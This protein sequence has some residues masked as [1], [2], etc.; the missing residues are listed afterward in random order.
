MIKRLL[1]KVFAGVAYGD[2]LYNAAEE[3]ELKDVVGTPA[4][5]IFVEESLGEFQSDEGLLV[6][7]E[8]LEDDWSAEEELKDVVGTPADDIFV[9]ESLG[10]FQSDEGLLV[11]GEDLEDD[12]SAEEW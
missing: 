7:G 5:D 9:E 11:T 1:H 8:D 6:T 10:E 4:D 2:V 12:W 3:E